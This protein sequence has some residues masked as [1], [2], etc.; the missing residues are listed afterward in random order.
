MAAIEQLAGKVLYIAGWVLMFLAFT[1]YFL[2]K[3]LRAD[4]LIPGA[5]FAQ[6]MQYLIIIGVIIYVV[7]TYIV[8]SELLQVLSPGLLLTIISVWLAIVIKMLI[9]KL[10]IISQLTPQTFG[11]ASAYIVISVGLYFI[12]NKLDSSNDITSTIEYLKSLLVYKW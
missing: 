10:P 8:N 12:A 4:Y 9:C 1:C 3:V 11:Q 5:G 7:R 2:G 6:K